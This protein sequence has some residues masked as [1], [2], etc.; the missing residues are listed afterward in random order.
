MNVVD[1][2]KNTFKIT[3]KNFILVQ[4]LVLF[5]IIFIFLI[6]GMY[7]MRAS[8]KIV[9]LFFSVVSL[10]IVAAFMAGWLYMAK[11][12]IAFEFNKDIPEEE[13]ALKSLGLIKH[14]FVGVGQYFVPMILF[15]TIYLVFQNLVMYFALKLGLQVFSGLD[16]DFTKANPLE[17]LLEPSCNAQIANC[18]ATKIAWAAWL[19][20]LIIVLPFFTMWWTPALFYSAKNPILAIKKGIIFLFKNFA[21]SVG[22]YL[23]LSIFYSFSLL[24]NTFAP[25]SISLEDNFILGIILLLFGVFFL[26][27]YPTYYVVLIFLYYGQHSEHSAKDYIDIGD[28]SDRQKLAGSDPGKED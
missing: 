1:C 24:I 2:I 5:F 14:F 15:G 7:G 27:Y 8:N 11:K 19:L 23:F 21:A 4:P 26:F 18:T 9:F 12:T 13:K 22:L 3:V 6:G 17:V 25:T 16:F 20:F 28:D 10:L